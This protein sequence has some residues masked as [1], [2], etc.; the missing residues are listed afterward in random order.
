MSKESDL[1]D[2]LFDEVVAEGQEQDKQDKQMLMRYLNM[3]G[4]SKKW[5][6]FARYSNRTN[7]IGKGRILNCEILPEHLLIDMT[8]DGVRYTGTLPVWSEE[9]E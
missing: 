5:I 2:E 3:K 4:N 9:E 1:F 6:N 8:L 7:C